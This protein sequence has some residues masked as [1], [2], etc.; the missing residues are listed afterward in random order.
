MILLKLS[1]FWTKLLS[2]F[3]ETLSVVNPHLEFSLL[4]ETFFYLSHMSYV[5]YPKRIV[6][7][8]VFEKMV[9]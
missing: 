2:G 9:E 5:T 3:F 7:R 8:Q 4:V 1:T 6:Q